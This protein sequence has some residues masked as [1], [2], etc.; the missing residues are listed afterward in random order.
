MKIEKKTSWLKAS[1]AITLFVGL[2]LGAATIKRHYDSPAN[3]PKVSEQDPSPLY[4]KSI[5]G[6]SSSGGTLSEVSPDHNF[7]VT[8]LTTQ[9]KEEALTVIKKL[10]SEDIS[11]FYTRFIQKGHPFYRV[12]AGTFETLSEAKNTITTIRNVGLP[13][14]LERL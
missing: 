9:N 6:D 2:I 4:Y 14:K 7:S 5:G 11:A 1:F 8:I 12:Q 3:A 10:E 13:A